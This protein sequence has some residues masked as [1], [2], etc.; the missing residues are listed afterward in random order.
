MGIEFEIDEARSVGFSSEELRVSYFLVHR[1]ENGLAAGLHF[2]AGVSSLDQLTG[3][4]KVSQSREAYDQDI[5][6]RLSATAQL[7]LM[8][9]NGQ[10]PERYPQAEVRVEFH[11]MRDMKGR[12]SSESKDNPSERDRDK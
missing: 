5:P 8:S 2:P 3:K 12:R 11:R 1:I 4:L 10:F 6:C 9:S 7:I